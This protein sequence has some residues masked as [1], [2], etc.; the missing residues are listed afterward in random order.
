MKKTLNIRIS[1]SE[2]NR[3]FLSIF[4]QTDKRYIVLYGG[5]GSSK[6]YSTAQA[7]IFFILKEPLF[8]LLVVRNT[9]R[10]NRDSTFALLK[11]IIIR[12][13]LYRYFKINT[14]DM[15]ITCLANGN[16]I[17]FTGCDDVEKLKSVTFSRGEL[18]DIWCEEASEISEAD[19]NQLDIRL[20]GSETKKHIWL[21]FNPIDVNHWLKRRF[22]DDPAENV[23]VHHSTYRDNE[24]LD[25][26]YIRLLESYK[27]SD[28]YYY[29]VYCLGQWGVLGN[30][31]FDANRISKRLQE[32]V[33]PQTRGFFDYRYD[34][35][36]ITD[37]RFIEDDNGF[38]SIYRKPDE[39]FNY[40]IGGDTA[41]EGSD[42]FVGQV[43][44]QEGEQVAVL[45]HQMDSDLY[46]KQIYCLGKYY[47]NALLT[48]ETNFDLHPIKELQRF[49]YYHMYIREVNDTALKKYRKAYGFVT[50]GQTRPMILNHLIE[51]VRE[52]T[53]FFNDRLS[54]EEMLTFVRNE[55]GRMEAKNGAHDDLVMALAIGYEGMSQLRMRK[56][57]QKK[58]DLARF[59]DEYQDRKDDLANYWG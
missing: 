27:E 4:D 2:F 30:T 26:D 10:S 28:P 23:Y 14:S 16:E 13:N 9:G 31:V 53:E 5:A 52:N 21:T 18:T 51:V 50:N 15:R 22:I 35:M 25:E 37:I 49:G 12:W 40:C 6:S 20:R 46:A 39:R 43:L 44:S 17:I 19:F 42:W 3:S 8:N 24:H 38:I 45:R 41:G 48:I 7:L 55:K 56:P 29:N 47:N 36:H 32:L 1:P 11:Q 58:E 54:L 34:G 33:L 59:T 57:K